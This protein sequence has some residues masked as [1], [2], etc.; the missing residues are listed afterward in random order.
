MVFLRL[1]EALYVVPPSPARKESRIQLVDQGEFPLS[2]R[3]GL[4]HTQHGYN[5]ASILRRAERLACVCLTMF[6]AWS[7]ELKPALTAGTAY[8]LLLFA[9]GFLLGTI[10]VV[11][12]APR[13]GQ[14]VG[15][16]AEAPIMLT[17][18][19]VICRWALVHWRV[20]QRSAIRWT[21]VPLFLA[22]LFAFETVLG[23]VAFGRKLSEQWAA[24]VTL[25]GALGLSAQVIA[26]LLPV[27]VGKG[28]QKK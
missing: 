22:L 19:Y 20:S 15:T 11:F 6:K 7:C 4:S 9:L 23:L 21:M 1:T 27:F 28:D 10:R 14:V 2:T 5:L 13:F 17:A 26:A 18:G 12:V 24:L 25:A 16:L 8:F 3:S